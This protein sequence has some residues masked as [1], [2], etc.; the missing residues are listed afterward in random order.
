VEDPKKGAV[1]TLIRM[2]R[3]LRDWSQPELAEATGLAPST[4]FR[5][6]A[7]HGDPDEETLERIIQGAG[8]P[9]SLLRECL[10]PTVSLLVAK[11]SLP[12]DVEV[13]GGRSPRTATALEGL[14]R[15][16]M[17]I[18]LARLKEAR[19]Q[20]KAD[21]WYPRPEDRET[22]TA[23]WAR[24]ERYDEDERAFLVREVEELH[25]WALAE[26]LTHR[27][28]ALRDDSQGRVALARLAFAI[29]EQVA[30]PAPWTN[31]LRGYTF[32]FL[33]LALQRSGTP[34]D[35]DRMELDLS[36]ALAQWNQGAEAPE[37]LDEERFGRAVAELRGVESAETRR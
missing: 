13:E 25:H 9:A 7:G 26:L 18:A 27:S 1:P 23:L 16:R 30:G 34:S 31:R 20:T 24:L 3:A 37:V 17:E 21:A 33:L 5:L 11:L 15:D 19:A 8:L 14:A 2:L 22:G 36:R 12:A 4:I 32:A 28:D 6:E 29:A 35:R 10:L